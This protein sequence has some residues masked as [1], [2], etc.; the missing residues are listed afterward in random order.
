MM[1]RPLARWPNSR[2]KI[3]PV[4]LIAVCVLAAFGLLF[5]F[6]ASSK[7][8]ATSNRE[9]GSPRLRLV[10]ADMRRARRL[11]LR[12]AQLSRGFDTFDTGASPSNNGGS[13]DRPG[14]DLA[15]LTETAEVYGAGL[16]NGDLGVYFVP[17]AYVFVSSTEAAK[18]QRLAAPVA[19][20]CAVVLVKQRLKGASARILGKVLSSVSR[21]TDGIV[22]RGTQAIFHVRISGLSLRMEASLLFFR[23]GRALCEVWSSGPWTRTTR[24][25]WEDAVAAVSQNLRRSRF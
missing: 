21:T 24:R 3:R 15:T 16:V 25:T 5:A 9:P 18:A 13:C 14:P 22:I 17:S 23:R 6:L 7:P 1:R 4:P 8:F 10:Q 19:A 20:Q 11:L 12:E 2:R